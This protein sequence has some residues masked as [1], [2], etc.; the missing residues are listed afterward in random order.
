MP[1]K[2]RN[3]L[4]D[5]HPISKT[6]MQQTP[7]TPRDSPEA[8]KAQYETLRANLFE[9]R[10]LEDSTGARYGREGTAGGTSLSQKNT[11][12]NEDALM[13]KAYETALQRNDTGYLITVSSLRAS[14]SL[15][16]IRSVSRKGSIRLME[17][18]CG[19]SP[20]KK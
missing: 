8:I 20:T 13:A 9:A 15:Q 2:I 4:K 6:T 1:F 5:S 11:R 19:Y 16:N 12:E 3:Q 10:R 18:N 14:Q 17:A 7:R